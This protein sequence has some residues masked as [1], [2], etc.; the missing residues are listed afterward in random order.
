M[1][2]LLEL[3][4]QHPE[5]APAVA[6]ER[7]LFDGERRLQRRMGTPWI[8]APPEA[9][10]AQLSRGECLVELAHLGLD[11]SEVRLRLRQ[12]IDVLRRYD[13]LDAADARQLQDL[14]RDAQLPIWSGDGSPRR[15]AGRFRPS[16]PWTAW[17]ATCC[18]WRCARSSPALPTW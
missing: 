16:R 1:A 10:S 17:S 6:L 5:L 7:E 4:A 12:V 8:D 15:R 18:R 11:W 9:L 3:S 14:D 13:V 2:A